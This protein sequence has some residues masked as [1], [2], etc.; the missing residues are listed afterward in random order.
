M[1]SAATSHLMRTLSRFFQVC[2]R[3]GS[4]QGRSREQGPGSSNQRARQETELRS[5]T[6]RKAKPQICMWSDYVS[7]NPKGT[8]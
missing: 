6:L 1:I 5:L 3:V 2:S 8:L 7:E 4:L